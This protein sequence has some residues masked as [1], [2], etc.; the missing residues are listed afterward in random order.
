MF[1]VSGSKAVTDSQGDIIPN[2]QGLRTNSN[3][4]P[5]GHFVRVKTRMS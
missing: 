5:E 1:K 4:I 2:N 3:L